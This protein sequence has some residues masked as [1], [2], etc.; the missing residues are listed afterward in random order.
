MTKQTNQQ[1]QQKSMVIP[2]FQRFD[3]IYTLCLL[4]ITQCLHDS[5]LDICEMHMK[6]LK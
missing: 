6:S 5:L 3:R 1:I 4:K 2:T